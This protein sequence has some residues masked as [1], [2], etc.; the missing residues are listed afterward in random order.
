[1]NHELIS[2]RLILNFLSPADHEFVKDLVNTDGWIRFIGDRKIHSTEDAKN[3]INKLLNTKENFYWV[4]RLLTNGE[5]IGIITLVKRTYLGHYDLG[6]AFLAASHGKGYAKEAAKLVV[7]AASSDP[8]Y[9]ILLAMTVTTNV[10]SKKLLEALH[11]AYKKNIKIENDTWEVYQ[12]TR[13]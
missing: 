4:V 8:K 5:A 3:Y 9:N 6:F 12:L 10:P 13:N 11:F 1:M 2:D 7:D